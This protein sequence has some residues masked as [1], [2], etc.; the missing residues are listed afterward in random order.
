MAHQSFR[1]R[2]V[3]VGGIWLALTLIG[4]RGQVAAQPSATIV[5]IEG[6]TTT[7]QSR[8]RGGKV[9]TVHVPSQSSADI[10]GQDAQGNVEA[11]VTAIDATKNQMHVQT[12]AG[13]TIVLAVAPALLTGM[14]VGE[15]FTFTVPTA[16]R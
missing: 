1:A 14:R 15:T 9:V 10:R 6:A 2:F 16:P 3:I 4:M 11:T 12:R 13:Q 7:Y 8:D 5:S